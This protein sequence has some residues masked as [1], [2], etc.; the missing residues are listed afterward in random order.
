M[1][2]G[3]QTELCSCHFMTL[4]THYPASLSQAEAGLPGIY[5][6][7]EQ[8]VACVEKGEVERKVGAPHSILPSPTP[9]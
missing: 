9:G 4:I 2:L 6:A 1:A 7:W 5:L 3:L 8:G